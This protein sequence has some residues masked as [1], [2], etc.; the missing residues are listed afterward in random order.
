MMSGNTE[1][2]LGAWHREHRTGMPVVRTAL[3][4]G[5]CSP[6]LEVRKPRQKE[7]SH[8][9]GLRFSP[10]QRPRSP[11]PGPQERG[12]EGLRPGGSRRPSPG[13]LWVLPLR[14]RPWRAAPHLA[15][16]AWSPHQ[17]S[18]PGA[19]KQGLAR[20]CALIGPPCAGPA[21]GPAPPPGARRGPELRGVNLF[22]V[23]N[24]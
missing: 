3:S 21:P 12:A 4:R 5:D 18:R 7:P 16:P 19:R 20:P 8:V 23:I 14:E 15:V 24:Y 2:P 17:V 11:V 22:V 6:F 1:H 13:R 9:L 10:R